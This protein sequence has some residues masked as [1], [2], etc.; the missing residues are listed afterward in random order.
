MGW[1]W[2]WL[3]NEGLDAVALV[4]EIKQQLDSIQ[5]KLLETIQGGENDNQKSS[6]WLKH[7]KDFTFKDECVKGIDAFSYRS[8]RSP[9]SSIFHE[10]LQKKNFADLPI[11]KQSAW[12]SAAKFSCKQ[13]GRELDL[14][15]LRHVFT[16]DYLEK[17]L[18]LNKIKNVCVIGDG[19]ANFVSL[20]VNAPSFRKILSI[21]LPEVLLSDW[22]LINK[23]NLREKTAVLQTESEVDS[24]LSSDMRLGLIAASDAKILTNKPIDLFVNIASFQEMKT[25][26]INEYFTLIKSSTSGAAFYCCNRREKELY[27]GEII[28]FADFPWDGFEHLITDSECPWHQHYYVNRRHRFIPIPMTRIPYDGTHDHRLAK[29]PPAKI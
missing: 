8:K 7:T 17:S 10:V 22:E 12:Y 25:Q 4:Q 29:Y 21:N 23:L 6:H 5:R 11:P 18:N 14:C 1:L 24:F 28:R 13:Q 26:T 27:D 2:E 3:E 15:M 16:L 9:G 20:A 19:Q